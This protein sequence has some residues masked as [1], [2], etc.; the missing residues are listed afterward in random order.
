[1]GLLFVDW[2]RPVKTQ[3]ADPSFYDEVT[4]VSHS[5]ERSA[6]QAHIMV[7]VPL[8]GFSIGTCSSS[9]RESASSFTMDTLRHH[10]RWR[11]TGLR[12]LQ[13]AATKTTGST[14]TGLQCKLLLC[15]YAEQCMYKICNTLDVEFKN[16]PE[17]S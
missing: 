8:I 13:S 17:N 3:A 5:L 10:R 7:D 6:S 2:G 1:L 12:R 9:T 14:S 15:L 11:R 4:A 16:E